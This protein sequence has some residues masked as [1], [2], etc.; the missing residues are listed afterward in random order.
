M[1]M[2][3]RG[4]A[5]VSWLVVVAACHQAPTSVNDANASPNAPAKAPAPAPTMPSDTKLVPADWSAFQRDQRPL[6]GLVPWRGGAAT[7]SLPFMSVDVARGAAFPL[8]LPGC[9]EIFDIGSDGKRDLAVC[10]DEHGGVLVFDRDAQGT[11]THVIDGVSAAAAKKTPFRAA[12]DGAT[13]V[14][15]E[16]T[17]LHVKIGAEPF[18]TVALKTLPDAPRGFPVH[19]RAA[20]GRLYL[21]SSAGEWGG[22]L[23][24]IDLASGASRIEPA[25]TM[26]TQPVMGL[27]TDRDGKLWVARGLSHLGANQGSLHALESGAWRLVAGS[28]GGWGGPK[29][30]RAEW[31]LPETA[32]AG[33]GFDSRGG[34]Y[35]ATE[36]LGLVRREPRGGFTRLMADWPKTSLYVCGLVIHDD[37]ALVGTYDAGV[38]AFD[39]ARGT[40]TRIALGAR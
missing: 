30:P 4:L 31:N 28:P 24:S 1:S 10:A 35:V 26:T 9:A 38:I 11:R 17:R 21:G 25:D 27:T 20:S 29:L 5:I 12:A 8:T 33:V 34:L 13:L 18:R 32:F 36:N 16:P 6:S 14:V 23:V 3:S 37:V 2:L 40:V 22:A 19:V 15:W 7:R 39:L